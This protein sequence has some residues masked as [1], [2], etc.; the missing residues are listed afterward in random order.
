LLLEQSLTKTCYFFI[1]LQNRWG[2]TPLDE[3]RMSGNKNLIKLLEDAKSAQLTEFPFPQEI[4]G[5][6]TSYRPSFILRGLRKEVKYNV[7]YNNL[8]IEIH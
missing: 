8:E 5:I 7:L 6:D 3:A 2:N 4:T 1:S